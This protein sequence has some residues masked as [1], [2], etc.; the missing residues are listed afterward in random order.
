MDKVAE[1]SVEVEGTSFSIAKK[2]GL[3]GEPGGA[4]SGT[5]LAALKDDVDEVIGD[6]AVEP[7]LNDAVH[8]TPIRGVRGGEVAQDMILQRVLA[9][10]E[11]ELLMPVRVVAG[12]DVEDDWNKA[13]DVLH[14]DGLRMQV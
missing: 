5:P 9:E 6:G 7:R 12:V 14:G 2:L 4:S 3:D 13:P 11:E 1:L 8:T 10:D